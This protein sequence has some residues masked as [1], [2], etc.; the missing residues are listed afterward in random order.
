MGEPNPA[1]RDS[2]PR[3]ERL[4]DQLD[5]GIGKYR[6]HGIEKRPGETLIGIHAQPNLR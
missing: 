2:D 5:V 6:H 1:S 3:G 4:L